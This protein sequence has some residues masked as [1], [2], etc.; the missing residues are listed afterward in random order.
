MRGGASLRDPCRHLRDEILRV[1]VWFYLLFRLFSDVCS[2]QNCFHDNTT[3]SPKSRSQQNLSGQAQYAKLPPS[4]ANHLSGDEAEEN[5]PK[6]GD[7][8][9]SNQKA[10]KQPSFLRAIL[11]AFGPYFLIGSAYKLL[12]DVITFINPQLL[13]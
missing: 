4:K 10:Q 7:V 6:E 3:Q 11:K 8:L 1:R 2:F 12:Q 5:G 13:R 9:L